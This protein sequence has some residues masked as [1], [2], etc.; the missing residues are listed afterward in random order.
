MWWTFSSRIHKLT[1]DWPPEAWEDTSAL[2]ACC[3]V[4][5]CPSR[6]H[7]C[8]WYWCQQ[9]PGVGSCHWT[10]G[11]W[12]Q[13]TD[14][15]LGGEQLSAGFL[16]WIDSIGCSMG[17]SESKGEHGTLPPDRR[18][19]GRAGTS[20]LHQCH[21]ALPVPE[22]QACTEGGRPWSN[23]VCVSLQDSEQVFR[24]CPSTIGLD[25]MPSVLRMMC[26]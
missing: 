22:E 20:P 19:E 12:Q 17:S 13:K 21:R 3:P 23:R 10:V 26:L 11:H 5:G 16:S 14:V 25:L 9:A 8:W 7:E 1:V 24:P 6:A 2:G 4:G 15:T 18:E